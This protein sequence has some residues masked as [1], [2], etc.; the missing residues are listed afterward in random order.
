MKISYCCECFLSIP[1]SF[2]SGSLCHLSRKW[3]QVMERNTAKDHAVE[4]SEFLNCKRKNKVQTFVL[5]RIRNR[6]KYNLICS[7]IFM[8]RHAQQSVEQAQ[9]EGLSFF[10]IILLSG[11]AEV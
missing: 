1:P 7:M 6:F 2:I 10:L 3:L 11:N 5:F 4:V 8:S 9:H